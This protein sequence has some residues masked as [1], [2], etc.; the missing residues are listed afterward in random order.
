MA[1]LRNPSCGKQLTMFWARITNKGHLVDDVDEAELRKFSWE[2]IEP[3]D[4][5]ESSGDVQIW[6][7]K[8]GGRSGEWD[9]D[10]PAYEINDLS[11]NLDHPLHVLMW[12]ARDG[13]YY[14]DMGHTGKGKESE[15]DRH[16][17]APDQESPEDVCKWDVNNQE[18]EEF[19]VITTVRMKDPFTDKTIWVDAHYDSL[20]HL[21]LLTAPCP[22]DPS[23]SDGVSDGNGSDGEGSEGGSDGNGSGNDGSDG[24]GSDGNGSGSDGSGGDNSGSDGGGSDGGGSDGAGSDG[25]SGS[26]SSGVC[27]SIVCSVE[28]V[29]GELRVTTLSYSELAELISPY[30]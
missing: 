29:N 26:G 11:A 17:Y 5:E 25:G 19:G 16:L 24:N 15:G 2:E 13:R 30:L 28:C 12:K 21:V 1:E 14:F 27:D 9:G 22:Q 10:D 7:L 3:A 4:D 8:D 23:G 20:G 18:K 6:R